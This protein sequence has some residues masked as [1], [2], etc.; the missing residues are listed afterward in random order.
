MKQRMIVALAFLC[1]AAA[2]G[3]TDPK[4]AGARLEKI[5]GYS[6]SKRAQQGFSMK[7]WISTQIAMGIEAWDPFAVPIEDCGVG[8]GADFPAG[9]ASCIEHLFGMGPIIGGIINGTRFVS[10]GYNSE[11]ARMEFHVDRK[12]TIRDKIWQTNKNDIDYDYNF[13]PPRKLLVPVN[14]L[15]C[16]D[17][18]DGKVDEDELDGLDNDGDWNPLTDDVGADGLPDS[19]EVSCDGRPYDPVTNNDPAGD[20]YEP[21]KYD[22]CHADPV[23]GV[24]PKKNNKDLY[25]EK[26]GIPDHGEP[27][28]DEDYGALSDQDMYLSATDTARDNNPS[29]H[30]PMGVKIFQK[31]FAWRGNFADGIMPIEYSFINVGHNT[32]HDVYVGFIDDEDVGPVTVPNYFNHNYACYIP[33]L[34]TA[35]ISNSV[36]RGSTPLG[37]TVLDAPVPLNELKYI[38]QWY[39]SGSLGEQDSVIYSWMN[40]DAF[41]VKIAPCGSPTELAD[42]RIFYSFGPFNGKDGTGFKPGD[43]LRVTVALVGGEGVVGGQRSLVENAQ[44]AIRLYENGFKQP[45]APP[46]PRVVVEQGFKKVTLRWYPHQSSTGGPGPY[47][48]WDDSNKIAGSYPDT[49]WRRKDPPPCGAQP[50]A[51]GGGHICDASGFPP[52]GRTFEGFRLYRSEDIGTTTPTPSAFTLLKEFDI[53]DDPY[54]FNIGIDSSFTDTN[55]VRGKRYWYAVTSFSIPNISVTP[56]LD[57][58]GNTVYDTLQT[59]P[60]ESPIDDLSAHRVDLSFSVSTTLGQVLV[61]PNPYRTDADYT[62]ENGGWEGRTSVWTENNRLVKFIHLPAKCTIR[63][64][65]LAGDQVTTLYHDDPVVGELTWNLLS[66]SNRALASGVYVF[67]VESDLGKQIGKFALIR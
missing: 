46:P 12:D 42:R 32:I 58:L 56:F 22:K 49:S 23:T 28:V 67:T 6:W 1:V 33:D 27:H 50:G 40:G 43:S 62:Y 66:E 14:R 36:D 29:G 47:D 54:G 34:R 10:E 30:R 52:G 38:F 8:I 45:L 63:V 39:T 20:N 7:V 19:L 44:K 5:A 59:P 24:L 3:G 16:D 2:H 11:D 65:T 41:Q 48:I 35:Y 26:N 17:D 13:N 25:T 51:C 21:T 18:G 9:S 37:L 60:S 4:S 53:P 15:G 55:L 57:S 61:V 31:S 64:F